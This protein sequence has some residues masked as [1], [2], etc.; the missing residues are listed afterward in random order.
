MPAQARILRRAPYFQSASARLCVS[1]LLFSPYFSCSRNASASAG[2][3]AG[4]RAP[5]LGQRCGRQEHREARFLHAHV[6]NVG[7]EELLQGV[8][9]VH[10]RGCE[11]SST[12]GR[13]S[14]AGSLEARRESIAFIRTSQDVESGDLCIMISWSRAAGGRT[15][16]RAPAH[17]RIVLDQ[18]GLLHDL[19]VPLAA[20]GLLG[21]RDADQ[22][23][24]RDAALLGRGLLLGIGHGVCWSPRLR[25]VSG[26]KSECERV[27]RRVGVEQRDVLILGQADFVPAQGSCQKFG[28]VG[29]IDNGNPALSGTWVPPTRCRDKPLRHWAESGR[30]RPATHRA[31]VDRLGPCRTTSTSTILAMILAKVDMGC[32]LFRFQF[33]WEL[34]LTCRSSH[35]TFCQPR[36][37]NTEHAPMNFYHCK[38]QLQASFPLVEPSLP[39]PQ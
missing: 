29:G 23:G 27:M 5:Y 10:R 37:A 33:S 18:L 30:S 34:C 19:D 17:L 26:G 16:I 1:P 2:V 9:D 28:G 25:T 14:E 31:T 35:L 22:L 7:L 13:R 39:I 21:H 24:H 32:L 6:L 36:S 11:S 3:G 4:R 38:C 12:G 15:V 8:P 20:V